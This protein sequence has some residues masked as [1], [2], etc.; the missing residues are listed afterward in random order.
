MK[1]SSSELLPGYHSLFSGYGGKSIW[2]YNASCQNSV[3]CF[4]MNCS[5]T[6]SSVQTEFRLTQL[7][8]LVDRTELP[9]RKSTTVKPFATYDDIE[10]LLENGFE[11][12]S[13]TIGKKYGVRSYRKILS[14]KTCTCGGLPYC[15]KVHS[16]EEILDVFRDEKIATFYKTANIDPTIAES[17]FSSKLSPIVREKVQFQCNGKR[18]ECERNLDLYEYTT[19]LLHKY[20][21]LLD[22]PVCHVTCNFC[23]QSRSVP[24]YI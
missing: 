20:N 6:G 10:K 23:R 19:S 22:Y 16:L 17:K 2:N 11:H 7:K 5:H 4:S 1:N 13:K 21:N 12:Q 3:N 8:L 18:G 24:I 14:Q 15:Q 9:L